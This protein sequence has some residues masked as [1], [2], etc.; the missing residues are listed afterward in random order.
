[1]SFWVH[2]GV[3]KET[4]LARQGS[5]GLSLRKMAS[6][7]EDSESISYRAVS[8]YDNVAKDE[9]DDDFETSLFK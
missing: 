7:L 4:R 9:M 6:S 2:K 8:N 3:I 1:M 5:M